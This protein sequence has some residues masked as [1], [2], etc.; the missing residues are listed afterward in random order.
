[1]ALG[2]CLGGLASFLLGPSKFFHIPSNSYIIGISLLV[3]G[4]SGPLTFVP[5][6]PEVMDKMEKILI[7]FQYDKNLLAD[8]SSALYVASYS[9][10]LIISPI[11]AGYLA[12]QYG[13]NIACGLLGAGSFAFALLLILVST[14]THYQ[15]YLQLENLSH[16]QDIQPK[17]NLQGN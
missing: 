17:N 10:G 2:F 15:N 1:M 4:F 9:F 11:L 16:Q 8:K 13:I 7:N 3:M 5:C 6:I 12:D 14:K